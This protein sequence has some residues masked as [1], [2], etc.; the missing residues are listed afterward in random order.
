MKML[1]SALVAHNLYNVFS[2]L[3]FPFSL[4]ITNSARSSILLL[5]GELRCVS[6]LSDGQH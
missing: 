4:I 5:P 2:K 3:T 6:D 1:K